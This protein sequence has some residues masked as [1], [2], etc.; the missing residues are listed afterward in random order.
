MAML[1]FTTHSRLPLR[2]AIFAGFLVAALSLLVAFG[3]MVAK[4]LLWNTFPN[5]GQAPTV[6]GLFFL[7]GVQLIFTGILGE[8]IGAI[9]TQVLG[10]P[11]VVE[12]E[13]VGFEQQ[14]RVEV[15]AACAEEPA[16]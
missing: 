5:V 11:L 10:R 16:P 14:A 9:H 1:G 3:Y 13:R 12:R 4:L 7:G 15:A 6:I 2:L 8:Y